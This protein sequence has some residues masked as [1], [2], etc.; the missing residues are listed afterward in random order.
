MKKY[1]PEAMVAI[2]R[3]RNYFPTL[4]KDIRQEVYAR[5]RE[6]LEEEKQ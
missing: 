2:S 6:L 5:M 1:D 3:Y 4:P